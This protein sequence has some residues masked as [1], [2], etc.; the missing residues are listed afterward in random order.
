MFCLTISDHIMI[1]HS[2]RGAEFAPAQGLHGNTLVVKVEFRSPTL[3]KLS[4]LVDVDLVLQ[5]RFVSFVVCLSG[6][7]LMASSPI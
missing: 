4:F 1:A 3:D 6:L 2:I 5:L 7:E